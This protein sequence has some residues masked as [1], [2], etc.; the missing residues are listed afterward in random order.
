MLVQPL[1]VLLDQEALLTSSSWFVISIQLSTSFFLSILHHDEGT[2]IL[3]PSFTRLQ[4]SLDPQSRC[5][6]EEACHWYVNH[7]LVLTNTTVQYFLPKRKKVVWESSVWCQ[8][9]CWSLSFLSLSVQTHVMQ[10]SSLS[11][12]LWH[13]I[14]MISFWCIF[15]FLI[16]VILWNHTKSYDWTCMLKLTGSFFLL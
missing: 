12:L 9:Q 16:D 15:S 13:L 10:S 5:K 14:R 1:L 6:V 7:S 11:S 4:A 3:K 8:F 2:A